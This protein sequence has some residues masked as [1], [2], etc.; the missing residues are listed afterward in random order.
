MTRKN[1]KVSEETY[2]KLRER[3]DQ[4]E[5]WD[6]FFHRLIGADPDD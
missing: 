2:R 1:L 6:G 3:K 4:Y 5:T